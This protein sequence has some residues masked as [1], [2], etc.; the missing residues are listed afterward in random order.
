MR[1]TF[2]LPTVELAGGIK[3]VAIYAD[4]LRKAGHTVVLVSPP[5]RP[6][7][8]RA[9]IRQ[10]LKNLLKFKIGGDI[11]TPTSHLH[12]FGLDHRVLDRWRPI[13]DADLPDA[14]VVVAT[15]W[16]TAEWL[17]GL[18]ASK[19]AKAY[20]VQGHEVFPNLPRDR[21]V[22]TYMAPL[23]QITI[24][25]WLNT[26]LENEYGR[27]A[28]ALVPNGVDH[29][30]FFA[31][32]RGKQ[33]RP[34]VGFLYSQSSVKGVDITLAALKLLKQKM[35]NL[36]VLS[37]GAVSPSMDPGWIE[38]IEFELSPAQSRL[39]EIYA[40]CDVWVTASRSEG[41]NLTA[42]E[43]MACGTPVISTKTGW[44][45]TAFRD[46][47]NG[48]LIDSDDVGSLV[49]ACQTVLSLDEVSWKRLSGNAKSTVETSS[50]DQSALLFEQALLACI[51]Q[52]SRLNSRG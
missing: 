37:F 16:E 46:Y 2:L 6:V 41:F 49:S 42:M 38:T 15:W 24:S 45:Y 44:P 50:W 33:A 11:Q 17:V 39:R 21:V 52:N 3:V 22:A 18:S 9:Q 48:V 31:D 10:A 12:S 25:D 30:Q 40:Q 14:D 51:G 7:A 27:G 36:R 1:V 13:V 23:Y 20:F 34:T 5:K 19:G 29:T 47:E 35:P 8:I 28:D 26:I 32:P 4:A 43:A